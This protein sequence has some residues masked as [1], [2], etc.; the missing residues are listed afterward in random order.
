VSVLF[1]F[2]RQNSKEKNPSQLRKIG[3]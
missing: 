2:L 1:D 3:T